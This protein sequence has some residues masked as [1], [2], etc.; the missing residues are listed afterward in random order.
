M[1][2]RRG[3]M[4]VSG[5][6]H[7]S[8]AE[9]I[10]SRRWPG[11]RLGALAA[12]ALFCIGCLQG[13]GGQDG[14]GA[15]IYKETPH[16]ISLLAGEANIELAVEGASA[17]RVTV[18]YIGDPQQRESPMIASRDASSY[19]P[20]KVEQTSQTSVSMETSFG[21]VLLDTAGP[22]GNVGS[23]GD[24]VLELRDAKGKTLLKS[25][26]FSSF[27]GVYLT[28]KLGASPSRDDV[29]A[30][31]Y[32]G[33]GASAGAPL[34]STFST[35]GVG[36]EYGG[37][38]HSWAPQYYSLE[39][40]YA[41]LAVGSQDFSNHTDYW[42]QGQPDFSKYPANWTS[43]AEGVIWTVLGPTVDIYLMPA[44]DTYAYAAA[45]ADLT[46]APRVLPR[47]AF[48]FLAG[49]WGWTSRKYVEETLNHFR[50]G[51][52]PA[53]AFICDF[54]WFT[55]FNDYDV[56]PEGDEN[57]HDFGYNNAT[58][59]DPTKQMKD[60]RDL[61]FRFGGIRKPRFGNPK[62]LNHLR[63]NGWLLPGGLFKENGQGRN[64]NFTTDEA[65][66]WYQQQNQHYLEDGVDFWWNDEGEVTYFQF[67]GWNQAQL[68]GVKLYNPERRFFTL[69]RAYTPGMQRQGLSV[70]TGDISVSWESL[71]QQPRY[72]LNYG[73][74]GMPYVACDTGGFVGGNTSSELMARWYW[75][76]AFMTVMR[77]HST[78]NYDS[79][80]HG[81][82]LPVVPHFP[83]LFGKEAE[84]AMRKA[85][86]MRYMLLPTIYSLAHEAYST[87][88][89]IMR[90]LLMEF[91]EDDRAVSISDQWL[92]GTGL[93]TAPV[94]AEGGNRSVY[95]PKLPHGSE[96]YQF[97]TSTNY[98]G[99]KADDVSVDLDETPLY[100]RS[101]TV[102]PLGPVIQHTG[103]LPGDRGKDQA[104]LEVQI[105]A[106]CD[107]SFALVEDDGESTGYE[108]G[109]TRTTTLRWSDSARTLTWT[110]DG[111]TVH[112]SMFSTMSLVLFSPGVQG[113]QRSSVQKLGEKGSY[114]F[115]SKE[116]VT[117]TSLSV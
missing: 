106:G 48:G 30:T 45:Y 42:T 22:L 80:G 60:Y 66:E 105:Y 89:P 67:D 64:M 100:C 70:W 61:G 114:V 9:R 23:G 92:V 15:K 91:G 76:S 99:G 73:L 4:A 24:G 37:G 50:S 87:G 47:Y 98:A 28:A 81:K 82:G 88:A 94:L 110:I 43:T 97:N 36:N 40:G 46:G 68:A 20:F 95:L 69:N 29:N 63:E 59:P 35:P 93:L 16:G 32:L 27:D 52:F 19:A 104:Q 54:F 18:S 25:P 17:F 71:A 2:Q 51:N 108:V 12:C 102:L 26:V 113:G 107:G 111:D 62:Y 8:A 33:A 57:Y 74:A 38:A 90:P 85:L 5:S 101:G 79:V 3:G 14:G 72:L 55:Q 117:E 7:F 1:G 75:S 41:A 58:F 11:H 84:V 96:W 21:S 103:Q 83:W 10:S 44:V 13:C 86:E 39:D 34:V 115:G 49:R 109:K 65:R 31:T 112:D 56:K 77:V 6:H 116:A 78:M 53:D